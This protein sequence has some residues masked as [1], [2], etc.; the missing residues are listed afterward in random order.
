M[1]RLC[2]GIPT[3]NC[4]DLLQVLL[5][6]LEELLHCK[7]LDWWIIVVDNGRQELKYPKALD[8][9]ITTLINAENKG[10][11][12]SWNQILRLGFGAGA[13]NVQLLNDDI[14][15][16][17]KRGDF[18]SLCLENTGMISL[19]AGHT[20]GG[21]QNAV[22]SRG[23]WEAIGDFDEQFFPAYYEDNDYHR[24][25]MFAE[26]ETI[27]TKVLAVRDQITNSMSRKRNPSLNKSNELSKLYQDKWGGPLRYEKFDT[28]YNEGAKD[29]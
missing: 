12:G 27:H 1:S 2:I 23:A 29:D 15:F 22:I 3:I 19:A 26:V 11:A 16:E 14:R 25:A 13:D 17:I 6:D 28:P 18:A 21:Y 8:G 4:A 5:G 9:R 20:Q 24:R 10:V 7:L